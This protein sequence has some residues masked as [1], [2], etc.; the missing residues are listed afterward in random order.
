MDMK[1]AE[2]QKVTLA[3]QYT[4]RLVRL[5][6]LRAVVIGRELPYAKIRTIG[7]ATQLQQFNREIE[8]SWFTVDRVV[9]Q[10]N[11]QFRS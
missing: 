3:V 5:D 1:R 11:G 4:G 10:D 7:E 8:V 6:G 9:R 2:I